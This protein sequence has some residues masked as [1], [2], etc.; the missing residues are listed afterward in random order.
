L[1]HSHASIGAGAGVGLPII[2]A[3]LGHADAATTAKYAHL[4]ND[5]LRRASERIGG[6]IAAAMGERPQSSAEVVNIRRHS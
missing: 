2:G 5:P 1:R 3:I 4:A 6:D